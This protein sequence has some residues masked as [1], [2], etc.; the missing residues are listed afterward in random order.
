VQVYHILV[1]EARKKRGAPT[2]G[3]GAEGN[4]GMTMETPEN[5]AVSDKSDGLERYSGV[6]PCKRIDLHR[7]KMCYD[8]PRRK[9]DGVQKRQ[10]WTAVYDN[11]LVCVTVLGHWTTWFNYSGV[12]PCIPFYSHDLKC[13]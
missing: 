3:R 9:V 1:A 13:A 6:Q 4:E 2:D 8:G 12:F 10:Q 11:V 5:A 7:L